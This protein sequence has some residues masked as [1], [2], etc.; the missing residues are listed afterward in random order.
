[1]LKTLSSAELLADGGVFARHWK[2]F[3]ARA[4]QQQMASLVEQ[5]ITEQTSL[6]VE[7]ASGSGKTLAYLVPIIRQQKRTII[8]T[9]SR[10]LQYQLCNHDIPLAI[11]VLGAS[12][13]VALLQG[14]SH[15]LCPYYLQKN[16]RDRP[17]LGKAI[18]A[19]L[20]HINQRY[21]QTGHGELAVLAP[22]LSLQIQR[23]VT[24]GT[25]DCL[26]S[27]CPSYSQCPLMQAR[28]R[29]SQADIVVVNHSLLFSDQMIKQQ[30]LGEL[31]PKAEVVVVDE[32]HRLADFAQSLVG[33]RLSSVQLRRF[34][35]DMQQAIKQFAPE[36]LELKAAIEQLQSGLVALAQQL[37]GIHQFGPVEY[38]A[39][40]E[41]LAAN[42][43]HLARH[44][45]PLQQRHQQLADMAVRNE[46]L[47]SC[48][49]TIADR[50]YLCWIQATA[51][52]FICHAIP[53][54]LSAITRPL[55][56]AV[57]GCWLFTSATL[58][59]AGNPQ[60]FI[61][62]LGLEDMAFYRLDSAIDYQRHAKL[63]T[64]ELPVNPH[65]ADYSRYLVAQVVSLLQLVAGRVLC[66]FSS[67]RALS[68]AAQLLQPE[69]DRP[70]LVQGSGSSVADKG[71]YSLI[72]AFKQ[73]DN[74]ILMATGSFWEGVDLSG[75][76]I[77]AVIIDKLPFAMPSDPLVQFR[78]N[79]LANHGVDS[80][81]EYLLPEA[82]IRMQQG[83]G[84]LLR[85]INERGVIMLADPRLHSRPY[86]QLFIDSLPA[87]EQVYSVASLQS[88]FNTDQ[89][90]AITNSETE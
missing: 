85:R 2:N 19:Q 25:D 89:P 15:Y 49:K 1:M 65:H 72:K 3:V 36:Q 9:A 20:A 28:Q 33:E 75:L 18:Q 8:S 16:Q 10:Y 24:C 87:M 79:E 12:A 83:C 51:N 23:L 50:R 64:P 6:I 55:L 53:A 70:L 27:R 80:F 13:S 11:K 63:F 66:L 52:G 54:H 31:L 38:L 22:R 59:V 37:A 30:Q 71:H 14:R 61:A 82:V 45:Q 56:K 68:A 43:Q 35:R 4:G 34:T 41:Q 76:P 81:A 40:V 47:I 84:R 48:L 62:S 5:G 78:S 74:A 26:A 57:G 42:L 88:F 86:G 17:E 73:A 44:L 32:A 58:S 67:H 90:T 39:I 21:Q 77:S 60:R 69:V 46:V 29:A 7:A